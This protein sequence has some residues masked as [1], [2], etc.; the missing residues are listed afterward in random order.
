[1][2]KF[3]MLILLLVFLVS[4]SY[5]QQPMIKT[6]GADNPIHFNQ[7][8]NKQAVTF[9]NLSANPSD[10]SIQKKGENNPVVFSKQQNVQ[11]VPTSNRGVNT[12][13]AR[14]SA[15]QNSV[16]NVPL[17]MSIDVMEQEEILAAEQEG[18]NTNLNYISVVQNRGPLSDIIPTA[19]ATESFAVV[20]GDFFYDPSDG[21]TGGPGG[22]CSTTSSGNTGD[23]P[24]CNCDTVTT[25][26]G[27][28]LSVEF[29]SFRV[30]GTFDYLNIYD[31]PDTS[32][33]QIYDSNLN[34]DTDEL[35]GMIAANGSAIFTSTTGA[36][37]F[38]FHATSV[39]NTCGWEVEVLSAGGGPFPDPYC[40]PLEFN[41]GVE[42]I[43]LVEVAGISNVSDP[44]IDGS[45]AHE[46]FT[47]ISGNM[48]EGMSYP[49]ALEGN[50]G[51][52]FTNSFTVFIDWNQDGILDNASERYEIGTI[53]GSTGTDGQQATNNILVPAGVTAGPTRMRVI[54]KFLASYAPDSCTP[55]SGFGQ[56][57]DYT[58]NV[59]AGGGG[60][61]VCGTPILE[62]NQ[63]ATNTCMATIT[64]G[65]L[66]Q[67][68]IALEGQSAG[69]GIMFTDPSTGLDVN[70]A[71]W[72][73]L[74]NAGGTML[75]SGTSQTDGTNW[76]DVYWDPVVNVTVGNTYYIVIEGDPAL[77]CIA[78]DTTNP[79]PGGNVFANAGYQPFPD[80]DYTFRTY[81][82]DGGGGGG[83]CSEENPNDFTFENGFNC[84]STTAFLTANDVTVA[85]DTD[86]TLSN[87]TASI[88]ANGGITNVDVNYYANAGGL[89]GALIGSEASV[90]IDS[91]AVI[92]SN[93][94]FDVNEV[95]M[96]VTP[97]VFAGQAG[98]PTTYWIELS[99]TDGGATGSV[100]WVVTSSSM[101]GLPSAQFDAGWGIPDPLM[102]GVYIWEGNCNPLGV[103]ENALA[104]FSYYPNPVTDVLSLK[105]ASNIEAVSIYNLLGQEVLRTE[106]GATTSD[107]NL[108]GITTGAYVMK[109]T[110]NGQTGTY[111]ILKN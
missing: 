44:V 8:Q 25:L 90:T 45:P 3:T 50:T 96:S 33:L 32:A 24:N 78:G 43:T 109:V 16:V 106:V 71:L 104:G 94:G 108:S 21:V 97:F 17:F 63:D 76:A 15:T 85:A 75:A 58:I 59:T 46:D 11:A 65:G 36:L 20:T 13:S 101:V 111:K 105:A 29:L 52:G 19:G 51:G 69:A 62:V 34:S 66:A 88:F 37:T 84:S 87:I 53:N 42:P 98:V 56:A 30:F 14:T 86:F 93:F 48:E 2:K 80:F 12:Q 27:V 10:A 91:Q 100:F 110:V 31:G 1:M 77:P 67:S 49:I 82:C 5:G 70:L 47:A 79:Y 102:D 35:A 22:D 74:P 26:T 54:K 7:Q 99:V 81:S 68:Y 18:V 4:F 6:N 64:Q 72:D 89:P 38:E 39:V 28:G 55:G 107:I 61:G 23:Y 92:G 73:G 41:S 9:S 103:S 95:E 40:G 60:G 57:E 83:V